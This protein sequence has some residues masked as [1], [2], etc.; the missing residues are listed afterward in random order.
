M[1]QGGRTHAADSH[2]NPIMLLQFP[3]SPRKRI[4][5]PKI[6]HGPLESQRAPPALHFRRLRKRTNLGSATAPSEDL[7]LYFDGSQSRVPVERFFSLRFTPGWA[8]YCSSFFFC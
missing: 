4:I 3:G 6:H 8:W 1:A 2:F 5:G 7:F